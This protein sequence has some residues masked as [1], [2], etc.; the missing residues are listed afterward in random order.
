M[1]H[2]PAVTTKPLDEWRGLPAGTAVFTSCGH[3]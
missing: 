3:F 1:M 2:A